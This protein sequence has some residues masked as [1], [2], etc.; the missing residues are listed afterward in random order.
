MYADVEKG[1]RVSDARNRTG[2]DPEPHAALVLVTLRRV[3]V[4]T[5]VGC[6]TWKVAWACP[7]RTAR[8]TAVR[9][10]VCRG[11]CGFSATRARAWGW[12]ASLDVERASPPYLLILPGTRSLFIGG[13]PRDDQGTPEGRSD[14]GPHVADWLGTVSHRHISAVLISCLV[15]VLLWLWL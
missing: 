12:R 3:F 2:C 15:L 5:E 10:R 6:R 11:R 13:R 8:S 1:Q 4:D 14:F 7:P 9:R